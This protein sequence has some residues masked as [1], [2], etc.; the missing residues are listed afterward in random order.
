MLE[1]ATYCW[2]DTHM[3]R[4]DFITLVTS[5][6]G[7][8]P[9]TTRAQESARR[10]NRPGL[11][12]SSAQ[13]AEI[14]STLRKEAMKTLVPPGLNVGEVVPSTMHLLSFPRS[15]REKI[16]TVRRHLYALLQ[17]QVLI[18]DPATRTIVAIVG[19]IRTRP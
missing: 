19:G 5:A 11:S 13:R 10:A 6:T 18:I 2:R 4:R 16:P 1:C 9:F 12:L 3:R 7:V 14:W 17:G 15:L 8:W